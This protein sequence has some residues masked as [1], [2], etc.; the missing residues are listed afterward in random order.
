MF[1][2]VPQQTIELNKTEI[3]KSK[4]KMTKDFKFSI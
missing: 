4:S 3:I 1:Y 2:L